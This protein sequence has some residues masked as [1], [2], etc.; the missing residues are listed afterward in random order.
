[1]IYEISNTKGHDREQL[2]TTQNK[3]S[4]ETTKNTHT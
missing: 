2:W 3:N 1:M 4:D